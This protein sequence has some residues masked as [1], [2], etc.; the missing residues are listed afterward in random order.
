MDLLHLRVE[1]VT[2]FVLRLLLQPRL[3]VDKIYMYIELSAPRRHSEFDRWLNDRALTSGRLCPTNIA[4]R[5]VPSCYKTMTC[6]TVS[7]RNRKVSK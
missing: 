4:P 2:A 6:K 3:S 7:P 5:H 1:Y